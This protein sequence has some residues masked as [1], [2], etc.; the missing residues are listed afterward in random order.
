MHFFFNGVDKNI[1]KVAERI[2]GSKTETK[3]KSDP[4]LG[5]IFI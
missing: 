4:F 5:V 3:T 2:F 1:I